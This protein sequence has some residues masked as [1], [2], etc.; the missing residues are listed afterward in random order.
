MPRSSAAGIFTLM[1][2]AIAEDL[3]RRGNVRPCTSVDGPAFIH[4]QQRV[5]P[6]GRAT[7]QRTMY[8]VDRL[9]K[10]YGLHAGMLPT[11]L[12]EVARVLPHPSR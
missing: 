1:T 6:N 3:K 12:A 9:R 10:V 5:F 7:Y 2:N 8:W 4:D 11:C